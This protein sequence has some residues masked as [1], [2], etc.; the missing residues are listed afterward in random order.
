[1]DAFSC[2]HVFPKPSYSKGETLMCTHMLFHAPINPGQDAQFHV[3]ARVME[4][5][6]FSGFTLYKVSK[7]HEFPLVPHDVKNAAKWINAYGFVGIAPPRLEFDLFP[8]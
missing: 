1:M 4:L 6:G 5:P 8:I 2:G 3:S 7:G